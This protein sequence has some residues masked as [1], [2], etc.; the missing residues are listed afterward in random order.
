MEFDPVSII[1]NQEQKDMK[2]LER[3]LACVTG[4]VRGYRG[5]QYATLDLGYNLLVRI[6][7]LDRVTK[8][9]EGKAASAFLSFTYDRL[10]GWDPRIC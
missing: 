2:K 10:V 7:P 3:S 6:T 9:D 5:P 4:V 1:R 8:D